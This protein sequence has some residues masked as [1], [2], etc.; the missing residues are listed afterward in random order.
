MKVATLAK[1]IVT[2]YLNRNVVEKDDL[3]TIVSDVTSALRKC[4]AGEGPQLSK[5]PPKTVEET[6]EAQAEAVT[7]VAA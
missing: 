7:S 2:A 3:A 6:T 5:T 1:G 4:H